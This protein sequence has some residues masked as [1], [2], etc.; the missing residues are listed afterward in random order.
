MDKWIRVPR[1]DDDCIGIVVHN[2]DF[3]P[4]VVLHTIKDI[5]ND[6]AYVCASD[7][8]FCLLTKEGDSNWEESP[9]PEELIGL[10]Y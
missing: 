3:K 2:K 6:K 4:L 8:G 10:V 7:K 9:L 5:N 1:E